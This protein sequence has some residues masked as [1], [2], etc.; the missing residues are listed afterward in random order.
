LTSCGRIR[1]AA[2]TGADVDS[3]WDSN[4]VALAASSLLARQ[5]QQYGRQ[6]RLAA[7]GSNG[8]PPMRIIILVIV[9]ALIALALMGALVHTPPEVPFPP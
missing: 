5:Q 9:G 3:R 8:V 4:G 1:I 7:N 6:G 2:A